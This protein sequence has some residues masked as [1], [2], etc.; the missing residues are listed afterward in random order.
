MNNF[1]KIN[2]LIRNKNWTEFENLCSTVES[3]GEDRDGNNACL[4]FF[5]QNIVEAIIIAEKY[6]LIEQFE[7][8][9]SL[10][11]SS[12][13]FRKDLIHKL[14]INNTLKPLEIF[15]PIKD[16][17]STN[18]DYSHLIYMKKDLLDC[19]TDYYEVLTTNEDNK[20]YNQEFVKTIFSNKAVL[21]KIT[22]QI[23]DFFL[24][25]SYIESKSF[26]FNIYCF[27]ENTS[28]INK[29]I[30]H[31][32]NQPNKINANLKSEIL[33]GYDYCLKKIK[34][35]FTD[36]VL[37]NDLKIIIESLDILFLFFNLKNKEFESN[38]KNR[39][40]I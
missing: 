28:Y 27:K 4:S 3:L 1:E 35:P 36:K 14:L 29:I 8:I 34:H 2:E 6:K 9:I 24:K 25:N 32:K 26:L 7:I 39:H 22:I 16:S 13:S 37:K 20:L 12:S 40:K 18:L 5:K 33:L 30:E 10:S 19:I 11:F 31:W 15:E 23:F 17:K 21:E 38:K